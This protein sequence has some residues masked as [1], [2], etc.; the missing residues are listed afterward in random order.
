METIQNISAGE[1]D[2]PDPCPEDDYEDI[3][4]QAKQF[5]DSLLT[6]NGR[7]LFPTIL[8]LKKQGRKRY[9]GCYN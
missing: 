8:L 4:D 5:I 6:Q 9:A 7:S 2:Y 1:F 3:S